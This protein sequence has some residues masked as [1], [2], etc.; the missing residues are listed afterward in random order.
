[1]FGNEYRNIRILVT[2]KL[3]QAGDNY[4]K[5][6]PQVNSSNCRG[7][8][9]T[10]NNILNRNSFSAN[11]IMLIID[12]SDTCDSPFIASKLN[13]YFSNVGKTLADAFYDSDD[14]DIS[15]NYLNVPPCNLFEFE[16]V[17]E[18]FVRDLLLSLQVFS[19][20]YDVLNIQ[21]YQKNFPLLYP[22]ITKLF[23]DILL[24]GKF[25]KELAILKVKCLHKSGSKKLI[26]NYRPYSI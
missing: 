23:F 4:F 15:L 16:P 5:T 7:I 12:G 20:M 25:P 8:L 11:A 14:N 22:I 21:I 10:V 2:I 1:M 3:R 13:E 6:K 19:P 24:L 17:T 9:K 18:E 26:E